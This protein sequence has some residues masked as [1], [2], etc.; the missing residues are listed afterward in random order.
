MNEETACV[1]F[2]DMM[3]QG[4]IADTDLDRGYLLTALNDA[5]T[6]RVEGNECISEQATRCSSARTV[7]GKRYPAAKIV[8]P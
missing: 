4:G 7:M 6:F 8:I 1:D 3:I 2:F 5:P